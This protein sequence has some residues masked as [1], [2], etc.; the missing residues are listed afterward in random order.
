MIRISWNFLYSLLIVTLFI[1]AKDIIAKTIYLFPN[2]GLVT[3]L[4]KSKEQYKCYA[5]WGV[6]CI[7]MTLPSIYIV[8]LR[9]CRIN[10]KLCYHM[11][12]KRGNKIY[13][14]IGLF[15][16]YL[17]VWSLK[18]YFPLNH[19]LLILNRIYDSMWLS[20]WSLSKYHDNQNI[21]RVSLSLQTWTLFQRYLSCYA[22]RYLISR[23]IQILWYL[24]WQL[25][26]FFTSVKLQIQPQILSLLN[27]TIR[28]E[29]EFIQET[30][31]K[32]RPPWLSVWHY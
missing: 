7:G 26:V 1:I 17:T 21:C 31:V 23:N 13:L 27:I 32:L 3:E 4:K 20:S 12:K 28:K 6:L 24:E 22:S 30:T 9:N 15:V 8:I 5:K 16:S 29:K 2:K 18:A 11:C 14:K 19:K 10:C 25:H